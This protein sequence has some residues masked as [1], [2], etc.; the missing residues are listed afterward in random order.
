MNRI[1][2]AIRLFVKENSSNN[3]NYR[4][5]DLIIILDSFAIKE[6]QKVEEKARHSLILYDTKTDIEKRPVGHFIRPNR[7]PAS[8]QALGGGCSFPRNPSP[9][10]IAI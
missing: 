3:N 6:G 9:H 7:M 1:V 2:H 4:A 5:N 8:C 10:D